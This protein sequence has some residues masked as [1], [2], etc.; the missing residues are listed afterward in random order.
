MLEIVFRVLKNRKPKFFKI[1]KDD[2]Q[3]E[4]MGMILLNIADLLSIFLVLYMR[5]PSKRTKNNNEEKS[6]EESKFELIYDKTKIRLKKSFYIKLIIIAILD[7]ISRS[8]DWISY[9]ITGV[10]SSKISNTLKKN[11][12]I[13]IDIIMRYIFSA[14]ILNVVVY[15]HRIFS[16]V[17]IIISFV[18]LVGTD[19]VL[20]KNEI[21]TT[22][23]ISDT[24]L[25][26]SIAL[27]RSLTFPLE[28]TFVKQIFS[29]DYL[30]P[31]NIQFDR[32]LLEMIILLI[33]TPILCFSFGL[34]LDFISEN[35]H[36]IIITMIF[37]TLAA[38]VKAF[39]LLKI[40]YHYS[41]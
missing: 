5:N 14:F 29:D 38:F 1:S 2:I 6:G 36:I 20:V 22:K 13:S 23:S 18:V 3:N 41:S 10:E 31:A 15:K 7:Y 19:I 4:Y 8:S 39:I 25:Y 37:Y 12:T 30:Y 32:G 40:I 33:I 24:F 17:T 28:D 34:K 35:V 9:S 26:T 11:T 27:I 21:G 16:I